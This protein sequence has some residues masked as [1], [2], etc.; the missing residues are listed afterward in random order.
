[1]AFPLHRVYT[2]RERR[3]TAWQNTVVNRTQYIIISDAVYTECSA[4]RQ[5]PDSKLMPR[6]IYDVL[7]QSS[8]DFNGRF[9]ASSVDRP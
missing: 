7:T 5:I 4:G 3:S 1:M 2:G 8:N 6:F 9:V